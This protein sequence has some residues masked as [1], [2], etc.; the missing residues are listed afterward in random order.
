MDHL[1]SSFTNLSIEESEFFSKPVDHLS[2][3]LTILTLSSWFDHHVDNL[4]NS[5]TYLT[6]KSYILYSLDYLFSFLTHLEIEISPNYSNLFYL[7]DSL[8]Y[9]KIKLC[10]YR[11]IP[12]LCLDHL[13]SKKK[14]EEKQKLVYFFLCTLTLHNYMAR[15]K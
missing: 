11:S 3:K 1:P 9:L 6:F 4:P 10:N 8:I 14:R 7:P 2:S 5:I 13:F 15:N 12:H